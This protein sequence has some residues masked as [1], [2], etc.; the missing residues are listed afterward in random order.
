M[1]YVSSV[2]VLRLGRCVDTLYSAM[3]L[4]HHEDKLVS[5]NCAISKIA[6]SMFLLCDHII[7][8]GRAGLADVDTA[9]WN[10]IANKYWLF[11]IVINLVR[12]YFEIKRLLVGSKILVKC[13]CSDPKVV[14]RRLMEFSEAHKD[15]VLDLVKNSCDIF[16]PLVALSYVNF[17]PATVGLLGVISS[18]VGIYTVVDPFAKLPL[19]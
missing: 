8:F 14:V 4:I 3:N 11:T 13:K 12:D 17:S 10:R 18:V 2:T 6:Y 7:W 16:I 1:C 15:V 9:R 5:F 19:A